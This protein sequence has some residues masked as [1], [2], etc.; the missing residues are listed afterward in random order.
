MTLD[1]L[2]IGQAAVVAAV[3][4]HDLDIAVKLREVGFAEGDHVELLQ[5]G[6]FGGG[7]LAVILNAS[8]VALRRREAALIAVQPAPVA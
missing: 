6:P 8:I 7:T 4:E 1:Q 3:A 5:R 2:A